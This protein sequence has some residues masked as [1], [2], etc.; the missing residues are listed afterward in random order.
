MEH[1]QKM[2]FVANMA[3]KALTHARTT[4]NVPLPTGGMSHDKMLAF[5]QQMTKSGLQHFD[6]GGTALTG[7]TAPAANTT[8]PYVSYGTA[9]AAP[10]NTT[11]G[12]PA[13]SIG[14]FLGSSNNFQALGVPVQAGTNVD[15]LNNAYTGAQD[16][17]TTQGGITNTL[18]AGLNTGAANENNLAEQ[19]ANEVNGVGP[20]PALASLNQQTG[21]NIAQQAALAA[22]T[23]GAGANA[24]LVARE[25]AQQ[26]A[27]TQQSAVGQAATQQAE[28]QLAAEQNLQNLSANQIAQGTSSTQALNS[29]QQNEQNVLQ[30]ANTANNSANISQQS[31]LNNV[32]AS[33]ATGN[34]INAG[35]VASGIGSSLASALPAAAALAAFK[36]GK[37]SDIA[38]KQM[39]LLSLS[40]GGEILDASARAHIAPHNFALPGGRYPIHD[41]NH[42]RNALARVSQNGTPEEKAKVKAA[43]HKKYPDMGKKM[44][45][46]GQIEA[47]SAP[48]S[49]NEKAYEA[50]RDG[51]NNAVPQVQKALAPYD[52]PSKMATGGIVGQQTS[53]PQ[54][55]IGQWLN[56][57]VNSQG[58]N[59]QT[60]PLNAGTPTAFAKGMS[61]SLPQSSDA[62]PDEQGIDIANPENDNP[63][64]GWGVSNL[65]A[66]PTNIT[67]NEA[68]GG[69]LMKSGGGVPGKAKVSHDSL[70]NDTVPAMLSPGEVVIDKD[71]LNDPGPAGQMA[72]AVAAHIKKRNKG[73]RA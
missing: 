67:A 54:S 58:P 69:R 14:N 31:A 35:N 43:V 9:P 49:T 11:A 33:I 37:V 52:G 20:N 32:N 62:G 10:T 60:S 12:G 55:Y 34:A 4:A 5:L 23:R 26:G 39:G 13:G 66:D 42:A 47:D 59:V 64:Q 65:A 45:K 46:G 3:D 17:L 28:Q 57:N 73:G 27:A 50:V 53:G 16:A 24:G 72:R 15:Q 56:S 6:T 2:A 44:A 8:M 63:G 29:A 25:N 1:N 38:K 30:G 61:F 18:N 21:N 41:I 22:G 36:G 68:Y 51:L 71:T 48:K 19:Y 7:A 70:K 40:K